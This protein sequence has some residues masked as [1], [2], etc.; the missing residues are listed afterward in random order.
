MTTTL[1]GQQRLGSQQSADSTDTFHGQ[2]PATGEALPTAFHEASAA[3]IDQAL[4]LAANAYTAFRSTSPEQR[5]AFLESIADEV[6]ALGDPLL[7]LANAETGLP[8]PRVTGERGRATGE[9]G[10]FVG[11]DRVV[12]IAVIVVGAVVEDVAI[13]D[14]DSR[15]DG[16]G[17]GTDD[18]GGVAGDEGRNRR[19]C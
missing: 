13:D 8:M 14:L 3:E 9:E 19:G 6:E 2:N 18:A 15:V 16:G 12:V 17:G 11:G 5:A 10:F 7:E 4:E 1:N